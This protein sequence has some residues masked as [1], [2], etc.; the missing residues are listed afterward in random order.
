[1]C[2]GVQ[3]SMYS[4]VHISRYSGIQVSIYP[5]IQVSR[6]PYIQVSRCPYIQVFRCSGVH[7]SRCL[8][9]QVFRCPYV[10]VF[11]CLGV[12]ISRCPY[13]QVSRH[14]VFR[15]P[16]VHVSRQTSHGTPYC[17]T[18]W[19]LWVSAVW[20]YVD[21][22][23]KYLL[24]VFLILDGWCQLPLLLDCL[25]PAKIPTVTLLLP[26]TPNS[27]STI[28]RALQRAP[29]SIATPGWG[30]EGVGSIIKQIRSASSSSHSENVTLRFKSFL[31]VMLSAL[32]PLMET[33]PTHRKCWYG[34][35][36]ARAS[37][38]IPWNC[39]RIPQFLKG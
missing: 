31:W 20:G 32:F 28:C 35:E 30:E 29:Y 25:N 19:F 7:I 37:E 21:L 15:C 39:F 17:H 1:M 18:C 34:I 23:N 12:H 8:G 10:Q 33:L 6:C 2:P 24:C 38:K 13:I 9:V 14:S 22:K 27:S 4:C 5:G 16:G 26:K 11:R 3:V 36:D